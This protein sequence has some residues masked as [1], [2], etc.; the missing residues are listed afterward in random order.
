MTPQ[1]SL[2]TMPM[3]RV[4][5]GNYG[6]DD[7]CNQAGMH[8]GWGNC[9][10]LTCLGN[11][12]SRDCYAEF[13]TTNGN[14]SSGPSNNLNFLPIFEISSSMRRSSEAS[15]E[16]LVGRYVLESSKEWPTLSVD[17]ASMAHP[18][19]KRKERATT[20][21]EAASELI[22]KRLGE[23]YDMDHTCKSPALIQKLLEIRKFYK[24]IPNSGPISTYTSETYDSAQLPP[25][26]PKGNPHSESLHSN[27]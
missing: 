9:L 2:H 26:A 21:V 8:D 22:V 18:S 12:I 15:G 19:K 27:L 5:T 23:A 16:V 7:V 11:D 1:A 24:F 25:A 13:G 20:P 17:A 6:F 14:L 3:T 10:C 4:S